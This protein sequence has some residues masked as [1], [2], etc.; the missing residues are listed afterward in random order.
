MLSPGPPRINPLIPADWRWVGLRHLPY[1]GSYLSYFLVRERESGFRVYSTHAVDSDYDVALYHRDV[2]DK[3]RVFSDSALVIALE[4]DDG[5]AALIGNTSGGTIHTPI[6]L[7]D[8][9]PETARF[10]LRTYNSERGDWEFGGS[11]TGAEMKGLALSIEGKGFR[12][13]ELSLEQAQ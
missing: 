7:H 6:T 1:H 9:V 8:A 10:T 4:R 12:V 3:V 5:V 11:I 2:S 13:V